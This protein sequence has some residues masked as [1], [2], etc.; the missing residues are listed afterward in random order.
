MIKASPKAYCSE[1]IL[2][3][4]ID[5]T[6]IFICDTIFAAAIFT[7]LKKNKGLSSFSS[8]KIFG[9]FDFFLFALVAEKFEKT[10][11]MKLRFFYKNQ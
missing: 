3:R 11:K 9:D 2:F 10:S 6:V 5:A 8:T 7:S 1:I 4:Y